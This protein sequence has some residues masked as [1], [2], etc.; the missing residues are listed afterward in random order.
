VAAVTQQR[1]WTTPD[2]VVR[3]LRRRWEAGTFLTEFASGRP[4]EPFGVPLR[5]PGASEIAA[6]F[7]GVADWAD[8]WRRMDPALLRVEQIPVGGRAI[9][10]NMIPRRAWVDGYDQL[11]S[12]LGVSRAV[13]RFSE[14]AAATAERCP[15]LLPWLVSRPMRALALEACWPQII[16]TVRWID[17]QQRPGM[18]LRQVDVPGVD[19][20]FIEQHRGVL[21]DLLD[22]HLEPGRADLAVSRS[23]FA[24][25]YR[26]TG[27][28]PYVRCRLPAPGES[29]GRG[30]FSE[31][32]VRADEF[33]AKPPGISSVVVVE[34]E[35]TYLA[36]PLRARTMVMFGGGYAVSVLGSLGWLADLDVVY[37]GDIDTHGFAILN[38]LRRH[39][40]LARSMLMDRETLLEHR[41]QWVREPNPVH[42]DLEMLEPEEAAV[43]RDLCCDAFGPSVRLE[44]ERIRF[45]L[46]EQALG[47]YGDITHL[48]ASVHPEQLGRYG[49]LR[50]PPG[51]RLLASIDRLENGG[52]E[53]HELS[54]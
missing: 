29:L 1:T 35:I 44:Q 42:A 30:R 25:R 23:D 34:N 18:Y 6:N 47:T 7:A 41:G 50:S 26:F 54:E 52:A 38:R 24:A 19:T 39:L 28:P 3:R 8:Q 12:L 17:E 51:A 9:G 46:I 33:T 32:S 4:F 43:Y 31:F 10:S 53:E 20:K 2:Q 21:A 11:W 36:F 14:L 22:L 5:G 27:K 49:L 45:S 40:G 13:R 37:W 16:G 15:R 48:T